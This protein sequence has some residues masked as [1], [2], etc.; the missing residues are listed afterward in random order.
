MCGIVGAVQLSNGRP[1]SE[2]SRLVRH[3]CAALEH[4]GPDASGVVCGDTW[5]FG[6]RRLSIVDVGN[7]ESNQ[8]MRLASSND[9]ISFNGEIYNH[10]ELSRSHLSNWR[11]RTNSDT[12]VLLAMLTTYGLDHALDLLQGMFAFA[13]FQASTNNVYLVRD[14]VGKKP[15]FYCHDKSG[16]FWFA[17]EAKAFREIGLPLKPCKRAV[18]NFIFDRAVGVG[19]SSFFENIQQ[20]PAGSYLR[21][22]VSSPRQPDIIRYWLPTQPPRSMSFKAATEECRA[23]FSDAVACRLPDEVP[24]AITLSGGL[25]SSAVASVAGQMQQAGHVT[26]PI[27]VISAVYPDDPA[28]ES[29][30]SATVLKAYPALRHVQVAI[31][32]NQLDTLFAQTIWAQETPIADGSMMAHYALMEVLA[33][34]G[35]RVVLT[36]NGGDEIFAGYSHTF[37]PAART[38]AISRLD[39]SALTFKQLSSI[40][41]HALSP[42]LKNQ[43]RGIISSKRSH[44]RDCADLNYLYPRFTDVGA[45]DLISSYA[46]HS[47]M[48]WTTPAFVWYE[49]RNSMANSIEARSPFYDRRLV[50]FC[51]SLPGDFHIRGATTKL[52]LRS[53]ME[54]ILPEKIRKRLDKQ[55][56]H[57]P[58][59]KWAHSLQQSPLDDAR[60]AQTFDYLRLPTI[61]SSGIIFRWRIEA[62]YRWYSL[63][64]A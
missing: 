21:L 15:L 43:L 62:L 64:C 7:S 23:L 48:Q 13:Y 1:I 51:L 6:H 38:Q 34:R 25:D 16:T 8:P 26:Q 36:G 35:I 60:F 4:R 19:G 59:D 17:S 44:L 30:Y 3:A 27:T 32:F 5:V 47:I 42:T 45:H 31:E 46:A 14:R 11:F 52:L 37:E 10:K 50:E 24:F 29:E 57:A 41:Y 20:V 53:A 18:I 40:A 12:E 2:L 39:L 55:G 9:V 58:I 28:D 22:Q 61:A 56:F 54:G 49:D 63:F 33:D